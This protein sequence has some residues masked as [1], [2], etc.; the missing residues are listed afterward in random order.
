MK[1]IYF[2][3]VMALFGTL[4]VHAQDSGTDTPP[5]HKKSLLSVIEDAKFISAESHYTGDPSALKA[6]ISVAESEAETVADD[7]AVRT[8][9]IALQEAIDEFVGASDHADATELVYNPSFNMDATNATTIQGWTVSNM[10]SNRRSVNYPGTS[11]RTN[12]IVDFVEQ[13]VNATNLTGAGNIEQTL[14]DLPAGHYRL[15]AD[16]FVVSQKTA[17]IE[18]AVGV[19]LYANDAVR[20]IGLTDVL[21]GT[22]AANFGVDVEVA[23]GGT[24]TI[25]FRFTD[26]NVNWLG[27]DNV[28]LYYVGDADAY[29]DFVYTKKLVAAQEALKNGI[30]AAEEALA[31]GVPLYRP[32]LTA[33]IADA[34]AMLDDSTNLDELAT[35]LATLNSF[36]SYFNGYNRYYTNLVTAIEAAEA[37]L[38]SGELTEG[39]EDFQQAINYAKEQQ[40]LAI[41]EY[42]TEPDLAVVVLEDALKELQAAESAFRVQNASYYN[43][44][45]VITNG[46]MASTDGWDILVPGANPGLHINTTGTVT[47]FT[48]PFMECWVNN[49]DYGQENYARQTVTTLPDGQPLPKGYY[50]LKAAALATRQN[51]AALE[52]SGV[53]LRL[54]NESVDVHTGNGVAEIYTLG[55]E[56]T[57]NG[58]EITFGLF[59]DASTNANWIAWDEVELQFVGPKDKYLEAY[60]EAVLGESMAKLKAAVA[61]A[62][63]LIESVDPNGVDIESEDITAIV[64]ECE[65]IIEHPME[66]SVEYIEQLLEELADAVQAFYRSGV[67]PKDGNAFD[68]TA[69]L[70]NPD[71][72][73]VGEDGT[74]IGWDLV[75]GVLPGGTDCANWWFGGSTGLDLVQEFQQTVNDMPAGNYILNVNASIRVDM[76]YSID[77]YKQEALPN[78]LIACQAYANTDTVDVHPFFYEDEEKGLTLESML[79]MTNDYDYRHGNGTLID[80]MLKESGLFNLEI[81]FTLD[82]AGDITMGFRVELPRL[83]GQMPFIDYFHLSYYGNQDVTG[84]AAPKAELAGH[85]PAAV[86]SLNGQ[87][88]RSGTSVEGLPK[89]L[90]IVGGRKVVVK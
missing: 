18:D 5:V 12:G 28:M 33:A 71:F 41:T 39:T 54:G 89:G 88:L 30:T 35:A 73:F 32:E 42:L 13:W 38:A 23:E 14:S 19:E 58:G 45:N 9:M 40:T 7:A 44:A 25:G 57:E 69:L 56:L 86:F 75:S 67:S 52:V 26:T 2:F 11:S 51:Q 8:A 31:T 70:Q 84:V 63:A 50:V 59:V 27:W 66:G 80:Y 3:M 74:A 81:P 22:N 82:E 64:D 1:K 20:E 46:T 36:V 10:K 53:T 65:Y 62:K 87:M 60:A 79:A 6:A 21:E 90:Y 77:G 68:F 83:N 47:N 76:T 49:V 85:A 34:Q 37:L 4:S 24:L 78:N 16:I 43:P 61:E 72:D 17:D 15:T 48:T 55:Y 29:N